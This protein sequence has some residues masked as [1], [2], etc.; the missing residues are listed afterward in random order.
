MFINILGNFIIVFFFYKIGKKII[1]FFGEYSKVMFSLF[2]NTEVL[3]RGV[4]IFGFL[5]GYKIGFS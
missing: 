5:K 1:S 2:L 4:F 3:L